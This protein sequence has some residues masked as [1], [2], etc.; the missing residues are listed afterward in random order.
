MPLLDHFRGALFNQR[1]WESIHSFWAVSL[2][3]QLNLGPLRPHFIAETNVHAGIT[4]AADSVAFEVDA[5]RQEAENGAVATAVWAPPQPALVFP[6][7]LAD[8]EVFEIR[9]YD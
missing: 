2:A 7:N 3:G 6:V 8:L 5:A 4:V 1:S 9:V